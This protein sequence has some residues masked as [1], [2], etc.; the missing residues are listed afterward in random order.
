[1][2]HAVD[3][4][5]DRVPVGGYSQGSGP[6]GHVALI[7][8]FLAGFMCLGLLILVGCPYGPV[9]AMYHPHPQGLEEV[10]KQDPITGKRV[11]LVAGV[12]R[13]GPLRIGWHNCPTLPG[14]LLRGCSIAAWR[15]QHCW[16]R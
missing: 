15:S 16:T 1:M 13:A 5:T 9:A 4:H 2:A 10:L 11:A 3:S 12:H 8:M 7:V 14:M 6:V